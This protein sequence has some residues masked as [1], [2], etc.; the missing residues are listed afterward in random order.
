MATWIP[1][2]L[3]KKPGLQIRNS[4]NQKQTSQDLSRERGFS[5]EEGTAIVAVSVPLPR[6][7]LP[8]VL[9]L[10]FPD[11]TTVGQA[12]NLRS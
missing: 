7:H 8:C 1:G 3:W 9:T 4:L 11:V 5:R 12:E 6:R 10:P 2:T